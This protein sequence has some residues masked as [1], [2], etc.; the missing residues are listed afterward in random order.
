M[1]NQVTAYGI[2]K[3]LKSVDCALSAKAIAEKANIDPMSENLRDINQECWDFVNA[4]NVIAFDLRD[5]KKG[6][7]FFQIA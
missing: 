3:A 2:L 7:L 6:G 1:K 4:G 5:Q